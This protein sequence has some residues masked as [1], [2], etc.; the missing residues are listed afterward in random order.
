M[1]ASCPTCLADLPDGA[2]FCPACG[3][4]LEADGPEATERKVVTT[5]FADLVGFTA[6]CERHD[7]EDID[8][9]LRGFYSLARKI[10][11]R[12]GGTVEKFIGDAVVG[13]FGVPTA[14]EDDAERAVRAALEIVAGTSSLPRLGGERL[15]VRCAVNTGPALVRLHARPET[16]EG[17]LVGDSVNVAA[18]LLAA[19]APQ[20][21]VAGASTH[22]LTERIIAYEPMPSISAKGKSRPV[23]RWL[24]RGAVARR[25]VGPADETAFIGRE[26]EL[27]I[28]TGLLD[29]AVASSSSQVVLISGEAGIGKS[30]LVREFFRSVDAR[31]GMLCAWRQSRCPSYGDGLTYWPLRE[32]VTAHAGITPGDASSD[33]DRKLRLAIG[34]GPD[35]WIVSR[36]RPLVGLPSADA[37][38]EEN[39]AAWSRFL[40]L[41]ARRRPA[42]VV[43]EDIHWASESMIDFIA[44][45]ARSVADVPLLLVLTARPEIHGTDSPLSEATGAVVDLALKALGQ[46]ET[47]RMAEGLTA[48]KPDLVELVAAGCGGSPLFAEELTRY[49]AEKRDGEEPD[50]AERPAPSGIMALI[51]GRLDSLPA[52][53]K[54]V[55]GN[56]A[57]IGQVFRVQGLRRLCELPEGRLEAALGDLEKRE[58]LRRD[59]TLAGGEEAFAF[60]HGLMRDVAYEAQPRPS[61][62]QKHAALA[63][64]LEEEIAGGAAGD[65]DLLADHRVESLELARACGA[66]DLAEA[67]LEAAIDALTRSGD[68]TLP[69]DVKAAERRLAKAAELTPAESPQRPVVLCKWGHALIHRAD[70]AAAEAVLEE[71]LTLAQQRD[72]CRQTALTV[73]AYSTVLYLTGDINSAVEIHRKWLPL[74]EAAGESRELVSLLDSWA[75]LCEVGGDVTSAVAAAERA[76]E[77]AGRLGDPEPLTALLIRAYRRCLSSDRR[78]L[79]DYRRALSLAKATADARTIGRIH[80][81]Y[82]ADLANFE[83]PRAS[84]ALRR[85]GLDICARRH[86][87]AITFSLRSGIAHDLY[88]CGEW[89]AAE[90]ELEELEPPL[91]AAGDLGELAYV[92]ALTALLYCESGRAADAKRFEGELEEVSYGPGETALRAWSLTAAARLALTQGRA[93]DSARLLRDCYRLP[94]L[95]HEMEY[96]WLLP[97]VGRIAAGAQDTALLA[98]TAA[99]AASDRPL[100]SCVA[101]VTA[102]LRSE[103]ADDPLVAADLY[104]KAAAE[105]SR[106]GVPFER[107]MALFGLARCLVALRQPAPARESLSEATE[108]L[109]GLGAVAAL[110]EVTA[111]S[112]RA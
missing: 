40:E 78:G 108:L 83:G 96:D 1:T 26:V 111:L 85:E 58:F 110:R 109:R 24:A 93:G 104:R 6:L 36:L 97:Y 48:G 22:R 47:L 32:I 27:G 7:P 84:L 51:A 14:H 100:S 59:E 70:F 8:A 57:V 76:M 49:L 39:F 72:D 52:A 88:F 30:R 62:A 65:V 44:H 79:D 28:L 17:V 86:D 54:A 19:S 87:R 80:W 103:Y 34:D 38:R 105:W 10:V 95:E 55:L 112:G 15:Q 21:V 90:E 41:L 81:N 2:R 45:V 66:S 64:W 5:L 77:V 71:A 99:W 4:R 63:D 16:G 75:R 3:T 43:I 12:F 94:E 107:A 50:A 61:R 69:L 20:A 42:V 33:V 60:W 35:E 67:Q 68:R 46:E 91:L 102:A 106:M 18:R 56:A 31:Q 74:V 89:K 11:E 37:P 23:E 29:K 92:R 73:E 98:T 101:P 25:G 82:G 53:H 13:L 9:A